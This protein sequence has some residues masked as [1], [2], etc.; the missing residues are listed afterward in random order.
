MS[1]IVDQA[2][3]A[4]ML[5]D[6]GGNADAIFAKVS[7]NPIHDGDCTNRSYTCL[8]CQVEEYQAKARAVLEAIREPTP[9]MIDA[10]RPWAWDNNDRDT[11][12]VW[13]AMIDAALEN[14]AD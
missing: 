3:K 1:E 5:A 14:P 7:A 13:T 6:D 9:D 11:R 8:L 2:A 4:L 12:S 10:G